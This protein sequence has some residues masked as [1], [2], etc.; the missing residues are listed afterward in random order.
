MNNTEHG[1]DKDEL[2]EFLTERVGVSVQVPIPNPC[3]HKLIGLHA[4]FKQASYAF[5]YS[6]GITG[7]LKAFI[8]PFS[9]GIDS[10]L[11]DAQTVKEDVM[12]FGNNGQSSQ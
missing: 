12:F 10:Y 4:K 7:E 3:V 2:E 6:E 8:V 1:L 5:I 9:M 11:R